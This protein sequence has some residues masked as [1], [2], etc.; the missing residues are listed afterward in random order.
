VRRVRAKASPRR[1]ATP[2]RDRTRSLREI[3]DAI[4]NIVLSDE[5]AVVLSSLARSSNPSFSDA[6]ALE[7][8]EGTAAP[9]RVCFPMTGEDELLV[10]GCSA[11]AAASAPPVATKSIITTFQAGSGHGYPSFAGIVVHSWAKRD[12]TEDDAIMA[13]LLVDRALAI[14]QH[15]RLAQATAR[16]D[17]RAA[18]LAID[19]ITS[20]IEGEATGILMAKRQITR[21]KAASLLRQASRTRQQDLHQ[22]AVGVV[23]AGDLDSPSHNDANNPAR[24]GFLH[25]VASHDQLP[26]TTV[27][28]PASHAE[29]LPFDAYVERGQERDPCFVQTPE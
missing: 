29:G 9:F 17:S 27:R 5:P 7:L 2:A 28:D 6:C 16:A 4:G 10:G 25:V 1:T 26:A 14:V 23:R 3:E 24:L 19:L 21:A 22:I 8:S 20:R 11:R 13:R 12:P 15:E 18:K